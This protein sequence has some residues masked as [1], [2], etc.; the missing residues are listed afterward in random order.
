[1]NKTKI[2][3]A[4]LAPIGKGILIFAV[5]GLAL[6]AYGS[7][8]YPPQPTPVTG[9]VG[10]F[11]GF[12][13]SAVN[14]NRGGYKSAND[15]CNAIVPGAHVCIAEEIVRSYSSQNGTLINALNNKGTTPQEYF[16]WINNG[17]PG[18]TANANDCLGWKS[19]NTTSYGAIWN[20]TNDSFAIN[21]CNNLRRFACC[22]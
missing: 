15:L 18:F 17:A 13:M 10:Q 7:I 12:S 8:V 1:M 4:I 20:M 11:V 2:L 21:T 16:A 3:K 14:G 19:P 5:F 9:V 22:K 6:Y